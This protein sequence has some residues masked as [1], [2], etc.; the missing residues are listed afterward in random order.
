MAFKTIRQLPAIPAAKDTLEITEE[1]FLIISNAIEE[2]STYKI[3]VKQL[4]DVLPVFTPSTATTTGIKGLV[5]APQKGDLDEYLTSS[6]DWDIIPLN[7]QTK[8]GIVT[9]PE[10]T[11][12]VTQKDYANALK[13]WSTDAEG[14]PD[15]RS[16][17]DT[18]SVFTGPTATEDGKKG[19]VPAPG[20]GEGKEILR[21]DGQ[22]V[23]ARDMV[24][25][26]TV[27][28]TAPTDPVPKNG[29]LWF[30][31]ENESLFV[32]VETDSSWVECF[33]APDISL[34]TQ[35][36]DGLMS[37]SDK[38]K[39]DNLGG[40]VTTSTSAPSGSDG[41][42]W[43]NESTG[44]L[45]V[46]VNT[47]GWFQAN[48]GSSGSS[49]GGSGAFHAFSSA[50]I[51][52]EGSHTLD[53]PAEWTH[54]IPDKVL[55][56]TR[57]PFND[58]TSHQWFQV[59]SFNETSV[60]VYAQSQNFSTFTSVYADVLLVKN[61]NAAPFTG[62][63]SVDVI[64]GGTGWLY[65]QSTGPDQLFRTDGVTFRIILII[66]QPSTGATAEANLTVIDG[67]IQDNVEIL[68]AGTGFDSSVP[69]SNSD[70]IFHG[71]YKT[72]YSVDYVV[73]PDLWRDF[74]EE[75]GVLDK[76]TGTTPTLSINF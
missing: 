40:S 75:F 24:S 28:D 74:E 31:T 22:W 1:D 8:S 68:D 34:A 2:G 13:S 71:Q 57:Y 23:L 76:M 44:E 26:V 50:G 64:D 45:F 25:S 59:A 11:T 61:G 38:L 33:S 42:L 3:S 63:S 66:N 62:I 36:S 56:S 52:T 10:T 65:G 19:L 32:Y 5:P 67:V 21:A 39:L 54:G 9:A 14:K 37:S 41:D 17:V 12:S 60:T 16:W 6:G 20:R 53:Y 4:N 72:P 46:Y 15:W 73:E 18:I 48:G 58:G 29:D 49:G 47:D 51:K 35:S 27:S 69:I 43:F 70:L 30:D 7:T 55:V